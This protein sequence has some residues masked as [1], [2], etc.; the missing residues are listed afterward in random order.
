MKH[1]T[2][3]AAGISSR[4]V[5]RF[6]QKLDRYGLSNH[7]ILLAKGNSIFDECYFAPFDKDFK[8]RMYSVS[9]SFVSVAV[10]FCEQDGLLSLDDPM[11]K[12]FS[13]YTQNGVSE[14]MAQTTVRDL[15]Q[16]KTASEYGTWWFG[17]GCTDRTEVYFRTAG[18]K[19][20]DTLFNYDSP[21]SYMLTVIVEQ[22]TGKPFLAYLQEK[23]LN[24]I[25]FSRDATCIKVPGGHSF[26]DSGVLCTARDLY[27]FARFILNGGTWGGK[28]YLNRAY[29]DAAT[30]PSRNCSTD[31]AFFDTYSDGYG[32]QFW[33]APRGFAM[34]GMGGQIALCLPK[35]DLIMIVT[36][37][38][39]GNSEAA[40]L[41]YEAF[42]SEIADRIQ[43]DPLAEDV[44][45]YKALQAHHNGCELFFMPAAKASAFADKIDGKTFI[46]DEN[47]MGISRFCL[48]FS[49]DEGILE[50]ENRSGK[51]QLCFGLGHNVFGLFPDTDCAE[52]IATVPEKGHQYR[53]AVSADW[54]EARTLRICTQV[55]DTYFGRAYMIFAFRDENT[56]SIRMS[57][58][59]EAF[60]NDYQ[61]IATACA[62]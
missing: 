27:L 3:E 6:H 40:R 57:K 62:E 61:G 5:L 54:C 14:R 2:P 15:L 51:K 9:K 25:G 31:Y 17:T 52:E 32:Y 43:V 38:N 28:Q 4:D 18:E 60:L 35:E 16:M 49:G 7:S 22:L 30:D 53:A 21:G 58:F 50:Y 39:Q 55:I 11:V 12:F 37:D 56:V 36:A 8:H 44:E 47:P 23:V 45:A 59:A 46:C 29:L 1:I 10:G 24:D 34:R 48:R 42:Y 41:I 13:D 20:P 19:Y 26:G 33:G